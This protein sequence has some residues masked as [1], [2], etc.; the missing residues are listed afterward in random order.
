MMTRKMSPRRTRDKG[1]EWIWLLWRLGLTYQLPAT[2]KEFLA[3]SRVST[4]EF[5][6]KTHKTV[7][8]N[9]EKC[10]S[11]ILPGSPYSSL[12]IYLQ[13][14]C[15]NTTHSTIEH[16]LPTCIKQNKQNWTHFRQPQSCHIAFFTL[17]LSGGWNIKTFQEF[18]F[19]TGL[20]WFNA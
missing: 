4:D 2:K 15:E 10:W 7:C 8:E 17:L 11:N 19:M 13:K 12:Y 9:R 6:A 20:L 18:S 1:A 5:Q 16:F 14:P 3:S